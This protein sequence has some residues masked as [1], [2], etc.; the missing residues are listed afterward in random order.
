MY[1]SPAAVRVRV[2][3]T[4]APAALNSL[5]S[6]EQESGPRFWKP[7]LARKAVFFFSNGSTA[8]CEEEIPWAAT[9]AG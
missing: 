9:R 8:A 1:L 6:P 5:T 7:T 3:P 2:E 4:W